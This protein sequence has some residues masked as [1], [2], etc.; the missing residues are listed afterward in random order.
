ML[1]NDNISEFFCRPGSKKRKKKLSGG[2]SPAAA[3]TPPTPK[4]GVDFNNFTLPGATTKNEHLAQRDFIDGFL[5][6]LPPQKSVSD[7]DPSGFEI[8]CRI[9]IRDNN[10]IRTRLI[11]FYRKPI[12]S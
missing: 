2:L 11:D 7:P 6:E 5:T 3:A 4:A 10:W 9:Q 8:I 12:L 1:I